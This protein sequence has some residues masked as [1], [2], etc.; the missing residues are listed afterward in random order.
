MSTR[1]SSPAAG[2]AKTLL[3]SPGVGM[4]SGLDQVLPSF[5]ETLYLRTVSPVTCPVPLMAAC[6]QTAYRFPDLSMARVGKLAPVLEPGKLATGRSSQ[7][8]PLGSLT[9]GTGAPKATGK[10]RPIAILVSVAS[11]WMT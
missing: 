8:R 10:Q 11:S 1:P 7:F 2:Q 6:S 5:V 4:V 9:L 3:W